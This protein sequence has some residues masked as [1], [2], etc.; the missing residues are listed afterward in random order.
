MRAPAGWDFRLPSD[1]MM[2]VNSINIDDD[3]DDDDD[4]NDDDNPQRGTSG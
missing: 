2:V 3:G 4:N 1:V